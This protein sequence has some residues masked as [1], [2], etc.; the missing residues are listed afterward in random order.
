MGIE[1]TARER[2]RYRTGLLFYPSARAALRAVLHEQKARGELTLLLPDYIGYSP[3]EGSGIYDPVVAEGVRHVF[4]RLDGRL[5]I[6]V[7]AFRRTLEGAAGRAVV[8]F[9][10][11]FGYPDENLASLAA[12]CRERGATVIEDAAHALYTDFVDGRC[13]RFGDY[14][15]YSLHKMLPLTDGGML[16]ING[17]AGALR[18]ESEYGQYAPFEYDFAAIAARRKANA[19]L[20]TELLA[21]CAPEITPLRTPDPRVTPQTYPVVL[22]SFDRN[23]LYFRLNDLGFGAVSLYHTLIEPLC[24]EGIRETLSLSRRIINLPVHQDADEAQIREMAAALRRITGM[25]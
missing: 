6:D 4:Y 22:R 15:L 5:R 13:G 25:T 19:R 14:T 17:P 8:L 2:E 9:V 23:E 12:L 16:R 3:N 1:K 20:W 18:G 10:H 7:E 24:G 21:P 11:Y